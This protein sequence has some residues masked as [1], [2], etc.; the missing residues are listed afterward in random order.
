[1]GLNLLKVVLYSCL[2]F[3]KL[4]QALTRSFL[5]GDFKCIHYQKQV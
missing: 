4:K 5:G 1:M 3:N 2:F